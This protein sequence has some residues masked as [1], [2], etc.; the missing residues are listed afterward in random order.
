MSRTRFR[1]AT[2]FLACLVMAT[3]L[4]G[5]APQLEDIVFQAECDQTEQRFVQLLPA[6]F[7]PDQTHDVLIALHGHGSDRWQFVRDA[8][9]ECRAARDVAAK[10][11]MIYV[12]PDYRAKTSWMGPKAEADLVQI[13][14]DLKKRHR[15]GGLFVTGGSMGGTAAL[16]F[17]ALHP[18]LIAGVASMNGTANLLEYPNFQDAISASFG[19]TKAAIPDEYKK[20]SAEYWPEKFTMP[21]G[22]TTGGKDT[23]VPP[24]SVERLAGVLKQLDRKVL[25]IRRDSTGHQTNY[26]DGVA[27]LEFVIQNAKPLDVA[28]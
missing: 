6:D 28:K 17:A 1:S 9:D 14:R 8:R 2:T 27:I 19:G 11:R 5:D 3:A 25:L 24:D 22:I 10:R 15:I 13:I 4:L 23:L 12:S 20:R 7:Q 18:D 16:T 21:V 26:E